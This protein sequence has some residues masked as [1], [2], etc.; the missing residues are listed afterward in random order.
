[1]ERDFCWEEERENDKCEEEDELRRGIR[2]KKRYIKEVE[3]LRKEDGDG[4][5]ARFV[6]VRPVL[7]KR[8]VTLIIQP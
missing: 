6:C 4:L 5:N 3:D 1:M 8:T 7:P 2:K